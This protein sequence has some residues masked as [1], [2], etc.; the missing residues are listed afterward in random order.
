MKK[1]LRISLSIIGILILVGIFFLVMNSTKQS[2]FPDFGAGNTVLTISNLQGEFSVTNTIGSSQSCGSDVKNN[3]DMDINILSTSPFPNTLSK[4]EKYPLKNIKING[5][6]VQSHLNGCRDKLSLV[7]PSYSG[8][9]QN[10]DNP[11]GWEC[12]INIKAN[13]STGEGIFYGITS[14]SFDIDTSKIEETP[15]EYIPTSTNQTEIITQEDMNLVQNLVDEGKTLTEISQ[16]TG[17]S[18]D[19][20]TFILENLEEDNPLMPVIIIASLVVIFLIILF[21]IGFM[22]IRRKK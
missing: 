17:F 2:A 18:E 14:G 9:C 20:V 5:L 19:K 16:T 13:S 21:T 4:S 1:T 15:I 8:Y 11:Y 22:L 7:N 12:T 10:H 3:L 6:A